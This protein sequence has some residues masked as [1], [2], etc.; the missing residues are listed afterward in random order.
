MTFNAELFRSHFPALSNN[1]IYLDSAATALKPKAVAD[2]INQYYLCD[3]STT[4]RSQHRSALSNTSKIEQVRTNTA[5]LINASSAEQII[6]T[7]GATESL[8]L[9]AYS[10]GL[11]RLNKDSEIIVSELEHHSNLIPWLHIAK[12]TGAKVIKWSI[13][14]NGQLDI[15]QLEQLINADTKIVA[16][17]QMSN[18]SGYQPDLEKITKL[19]HQ[20]NAKVV[21]DGA[22][23]IVHKPIDVQILDIDFYTFS[24]HKLYGPTGLGVLYAKKELLEEMDIWHGGG[25]MIQTVS[26]EHFEPAPIPQ[27]FEAG[28]PHIAG[29][30]GFG[31]SLE[32]LAQYPHA[33]TEKYTANLANYLHNKLSDIADCKTYSEQ[34]SPVVSFTIGDLH[35]YDIAT[36]LAEQNIAVRN[37]ELCAS[38]LIKALG[39]KGVIRASLMPYN[40]QADIDKFIIA[41]QNAVEILR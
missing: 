3:T 23:G 38:P 1:A 10:Y 24:C 12:L 35:P 7:R 8:N 25:K 19:A 11:N 4:L 29:I 31:Q 36:L 5:K 21:V 15:K 14:P 13:T 28:T 26:F 39:I 41:L 27:K 17:T 30:I 16:V 34:Q 33:I 2:A 9:I 40:N 6:W 22:Q 32:F 20:Y 18:V 37:G